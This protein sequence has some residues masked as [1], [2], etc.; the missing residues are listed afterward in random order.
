MPKVLSAAEIAQFEADGY[1]FPLDCMGADEAAQC[2]ARFEAFER[3]VGKSAHR[4][5][6]VKSHLA[7]PWLV[8]IARHPRILDAV[9]D[10]N[11]QLVLSKQKADFMRVWDHIKDAHDSGE[12][13]EGKLVRRI[14]G[15]IVVD[16][17]GVGGSSSGSVGV[18]NLHISCGLGNAMGMLYNAHR[19]GTPLLVTA[20]QQDRRL[21]FSEPVLWGDMVQVAR[22]WTK[23]A[24]EV[25]RVPG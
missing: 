22:P 14:K 4:V 21:S 17:F 11:G 20:G 12:L 23:W 3:D 10:Q 13:V 1:L 16:L 7:F 18:V 8:E 19:A 9:E 6:R 15:G 5:L 24:A 25:N 2:R